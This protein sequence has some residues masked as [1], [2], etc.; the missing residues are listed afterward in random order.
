MEGSEREQN[1]CDWDRRLL[2]NSGIPK[3]SSIILQRKKERNKERKKKRKKECKV[4]EG[5]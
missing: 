2:K 1:L 4:E 5:K 3:N